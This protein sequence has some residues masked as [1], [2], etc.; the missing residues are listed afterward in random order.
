MSTIE[1]VTALFKDG[2]SKL[3]LISGKPTDDDLER[4]RML[5]SN[6]MKYVKLP[7]G[8]YEEGLITT[9]AEYKA[10][11][12]GSTFDRFG[13]LLEAYNPAIPS[14]ATTADRMQAEREWT[15]KLLRQNPPPGR[16]T[17]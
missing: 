12:A 17:W 10:S 15:S 6:L 16:W 9:G 1:E 11:R 14:D 4:P 5:L 13:T 8:T 7:G 2:S 3:T